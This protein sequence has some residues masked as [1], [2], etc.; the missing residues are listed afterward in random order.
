VP[1]AA[2][3]DAARHASSDTTRMYDRSRSAWRE[4]P[5]HKLDF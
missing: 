4:H 2:V 5:T 3:Q 1:L